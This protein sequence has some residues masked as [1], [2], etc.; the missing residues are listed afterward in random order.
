[1]DNCG[2]E[3][4]TDLCLADFLITSKVVSSV[5]LRI[6]DQP[7]FVSDTTPS[8]LKWSLNQLLNSAGELSVIAQRW[9]KYLDDKIWTVHSDPFWTYPHCYN[10]MNS[11]DS[12]LYSQLA[13]DA[14]VIFKGDL[15][16]RKLVGDVN[17]QTT[18]PFPQAL[19][20]FRPSDILA[21]RTAKADVM[22]GLQDGQAES[23]AAKDETWML[24]GKWGVIQYAKL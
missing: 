24:T 10:E 13:Q 1:M 7:W 22:V 16:Y 6:K 12:D 2:F 18:T 17:W 4:F 8:D 14:L 23:T 3:L 11:V 15:N 20:E 19:R 21:I 5:K 9:Q